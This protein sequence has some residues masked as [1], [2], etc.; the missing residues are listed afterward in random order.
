D[1]P[2]LD[3][4]LGELYESDKK[5]ENAV[6]AYKAGIAKQPTSPLVRGLARAQSRTTTPDDALKT[7]G[8]WR[9]GTPDDGEARARLG[10]I[11]ESAHQYDRALA[12]YE[13]A[14]AVTPDNPVILNNVAWLYFLR[15]DDR[16]IATAERAYAAAPQSPKV[17]DT[18]G[19]ILV[20]KGDAKRGL[21]LLRQ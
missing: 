11:L 12:E 5:Y 21:D 18:L 14:L 19:W 7:L 4:L 9:Q 3:L 2:N 20:N 15:S 17:Q 6:R 1:A 10:G 16:A 13:K 8:D